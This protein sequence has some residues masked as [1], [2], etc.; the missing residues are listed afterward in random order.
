MN[1]IDCDFDVTY[2]QYIDSSN[3]D[4]SDTMYRKDLLTFFK[5]TTYNDTV[6]SI[7]TDKL[8]HVLKDDP[9]FVE[10]FTLTLNNQMVALMS[11]N[12]EI[13]SASLTLFFSYDYF[14]AFIKCLKDYKTTKDI[15]N[16]NFNSLRTLIVNNC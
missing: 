2:R 7:R 10:L 13:N 9:K 3:Q 11:N 1:F 15:T 8:F 5:C 12:N 14:D 16:E 6:I 4:L